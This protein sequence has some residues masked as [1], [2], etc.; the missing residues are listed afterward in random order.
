MVVVVVFFP[1]VA[2]MS[3]ASSEK[4]RFGVDS[5]GSKKREEHKE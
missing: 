4:T 2:V 1:V 3:S 5:V